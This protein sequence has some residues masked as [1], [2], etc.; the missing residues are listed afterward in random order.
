M[1]YETK[2]LSISKW[3]ENDQPQ[4]KI[5]LK[6]RLALSDAELISILLGKECPFSIAQVILAQYDNNLFELSKASYYDLIKFNRIGKQRA[7]T[8]IAAFELARRKQYSEVHPK[9]MI[10][11][12]ADSYYAFLP[13]MEGLPH[14][15]FYVMLINKGNRLIAIQKIS[16]GGISGTVVDPKVVFKLALDHHATGLILAHNHPSGNTKPS[17]QDIRI[18]QK[19]KDAGA[20]LEINVLDH[21]ILADNAFFS[22]SDEG[23]I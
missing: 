4:E 19:I 3:A 14:E 5:L 15:T 21:L 2:E 18:T 17:E 23:M 9:A 8:L 1:K 22:F 10:R 7:T 6:G 16:E 11:K 13:F 12:S 20:L